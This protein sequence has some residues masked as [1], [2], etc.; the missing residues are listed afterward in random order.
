[1]K[2]LLLLLARTNSQLEARTSSRL[3]DGPR[4]RRIEEGLEQLDDA[5]VI[6]KSES[7]NDRK[8]S[9]LLRAA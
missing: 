1:M 3:E 9:E 2:L 7:C 8:L 4:R 6:V 5:E